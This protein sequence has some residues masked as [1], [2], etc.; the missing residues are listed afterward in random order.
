MNNITSPTLEYAW[1]EPYVYVIKMEENKEQKDQENMEY[2]FAHMKSPDFSGELNGLTAYMSYLGGTLKKIEVLKRYTNRLS[3]KIEDNKDGL[4]YVDSNHACA[5][6]EMLEGRISEIQSQY[7]EM[8]DLIPGDL[9]GD[10]NKVFRT[11]VDEPIDMVILAE[12]AMKLI[13]KYLENLNAEIG[14]IKG[15]INKT[16]YINKKNTGKIDQ[17]AQA[18]V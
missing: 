14:D 8:Q 7:I 10:Y 12:N 6:V 2:L 1:P 5:S 17:S 9:K 4:D 16:P 11:A 13:G 3:F 15:K 18:C